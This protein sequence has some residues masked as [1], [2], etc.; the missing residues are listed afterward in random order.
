MDARE[1]AARGVCATLRSRGH[2]AYLAG[3]CVRDLLLG[4]KPGDYDVATDATPEE[5]ATIF[6][7]TAG[8]GAAF[9]VMLVLL[10]EGPVEVATFRTDGAYL[11]GRR[12][13]TVRF[14]DAEE[15]ARR[16]DFTIN[17]MFLDPETD[18]VL[19]YVGGRADLE[20]G[21]IRAVG[22]P[23][24]RFEEDHLRLLRAVRF[25][26]RLNYR[27]EA[28]TLD[29]IRA[30]AG[31]IHRT[32]AERIRDE[33]LKMLTH[34]SAPESLR[35]LD[36]TGLLK[37]VLPEVDSM[38]GVRQPPEHHPEG[39]VFVHTLLVMGVLNQPS[40]ALALGALLHD[41]GKPATF[42]ETDRIRFYG[43]DEV[44]AEMASAVANRL[45]LSRRDV[46]RVTWLVREHM[47]V[48]HVPGMR[49]SKRKRFVRQEG[50]DEL[51]EL[52]RA[53]C[54][55]S[56][57]D[58]SLLRQILDYLAT[59]GPEA[60]S[61]LRLISGKDLIA[62]GHV[63]GPRFQSMLRAIEDA[64]LEGAFVTREEALAWLTDHYPANEA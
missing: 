5:V 22:D 43:H 1:A 16:R 30:L 41:C 12:P 28:V 63:P 50:F 32:S 9:G 47:H 4:A 21:I 31:R 51:M 62:M 45:K 46:E 26:A 61:P 40:P 39:D 29:A 37:E 15:D 59:L 58:L 25:A 36:E 54:L 49:E 34:P 8:V 24:L 23:M 17:A 55:A 18:T 6:P 44:G 48:A 19:D 2:R 13:S 11:D 56:H 10:A 60:A 64:Q 20:A 33:L 27:I 14:C 3:G 38:K 42:T 35:L 7:R 57:G 52:C 53:D